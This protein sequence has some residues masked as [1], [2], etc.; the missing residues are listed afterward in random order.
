MDAAFYLRL[1]L[2]RQGH[3]LE[4]TSWFLVDVGLSLQLCF[5]RIVGLTPHF[6]GVVGLS[7]HLFFGGRIFSNLFYVWVAVVLL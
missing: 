2:G 6:W 7:P 1:G 3:G 5:W 4:S